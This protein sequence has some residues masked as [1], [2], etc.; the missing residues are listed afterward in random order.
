MEMKK[1]NPQYGYLRMAMQ[2]KNI[3][4]ININKDIVR[5]ILQKN[6]KNYPGNNN[7]PSWLSFIANAKNSLWSIDLFRCESILLK[8]H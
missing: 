7:G 1:R 4:G 5:R 3:I 6:F 8:S 2:I